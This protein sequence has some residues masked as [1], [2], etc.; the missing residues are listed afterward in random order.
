M[1]IQD[2]P[3]NDNGA[4][5][6]NLNDNLLVLGAMLQTALSVP[7]VDM[8]VEKGTMSVRCLQPDTV[9]TINSHLSD[10]A[11]GVI[12]DSQYI[13]PRAKPSEQKERIF[14]LY[15]Q[16]YTQA[17]IARMLGISQA[18]VSRILNGD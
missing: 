7:G 12:V 5:Q 11:N 6:R 10:N 2:P 17:Q 9:L 18:S 16:G 3:Y 1:Q 14:D 8:H 4:P 15:A 13:A